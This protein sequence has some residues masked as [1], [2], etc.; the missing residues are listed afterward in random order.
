MWESLVKQ[1]KASQKRNQWSWCCKMWEHTKSMRKKNQRGKL[2]D[3]KEEEKSAKKK[4]KRGIRK[5]QQ[6]LQDSFLKFSDWRSWVPFS[7]SYH[8][9]SLTFRLWSRCGNFCLEDSC[10]HFGLG[11]WYRITDS[12]DSFWSFLSVICHLDLFSVSFVIGI[13]C[14]CRSISKW[15]LWSQC[16]MPRHDSAASLWSHVT[17]SYDSSFWCLDLWPHVDFLTHHDLD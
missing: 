9:D 4:Y 14:Q 2:N 11:L 1:F 17:V 10:I 15:Q 7:D 13:F 3:I 16:N 5:Q 12:N 6:I 8:Y